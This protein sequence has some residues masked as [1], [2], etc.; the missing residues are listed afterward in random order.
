MHLVRHTLPK[1]LTFSGSN[2]IIRLIF[3]S[4]LFANALQGLGA[5]RASCRIGGSPYS[6]QTAKATCHV[7][8]FREKAQVA[9]DADSLHIRQKPQGVNVKGTAYRYEDEEKLTITWQPH[10]LNVASNHRYTKPGVGGVYAATS[11]ETA[12]REVMHYGVDMNRRVLVTRHYELHNALDLTNPET[13]KLLGVTLEDITG[14]CYELTHRLGDFALQNSY[15]GLVVPSAR[16][17]GGVNI[18]VFKGL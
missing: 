15:D 18:V 8:P 3:L 5:E 10:A 17:V 4:L 6:L 7:L 14:D 12:F 9:N 1:A 13:R 11:V 16:N 2:I